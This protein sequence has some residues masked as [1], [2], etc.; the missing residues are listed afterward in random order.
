MKAYMTNGTYDFLEKLKEKHEIDLFLI[1]HNGEKAIA[2]YESN[3]RSI[4]QTSRNYEIIAKEG[5]LAETGYASLLHMPIT[6]EGRPLFEHEWKEKVSDI[7]QLNG[8]I[9]VRI[10]RPVKGREYIIFTEWA[11]N[12]AY[13]VQKNYFTE[14]EKKP[15]SA[16]A[17]YEMTYNVGDLEE[18]E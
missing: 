5:N 4:F 9:S 17:N 16:G 10:L 12:D 11:H 7:A 18:E 13:Q 14:N 3:E 2:Y 6:E 15:Y 1:M 8:V